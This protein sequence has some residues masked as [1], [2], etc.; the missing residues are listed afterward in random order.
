[1]IVLDNSFLTL[2]FHPAARPPLDPSTRMPVERLGERIE[3]LIEVLEEDRETIIIPTPVLTEFLI[4]AGKDG[5]HYLSKINDNRNFRIESFLD[6]IHGR[7]VAPRCDTE[8][9]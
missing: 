9:A 7:C 1:M 2:M 8:I 5:S 6:F 3:L 4:L